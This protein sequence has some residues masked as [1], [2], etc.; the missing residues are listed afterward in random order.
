MDKEFKPK[1]W[2]N[3]EVGEIVKV[4]KEEQ[5]PADLVFLK[6][7]E[8]NG[9]SFVDTMNLDGEVSNSFNFINSVHGLL[10]V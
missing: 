10:I 4:M 7:S 3:I 2:K 8:G 9:I 6:S 1:D 5:F